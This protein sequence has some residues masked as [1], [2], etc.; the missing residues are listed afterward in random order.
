MAAAAL[1]L[2]HVAVTM[3][4]IFGSLGAGL[5]ALSLGL[6]PA[7]PPRGRARGPCW[8]SSSPGKRSGEVLALALSPLWI[9]SVGALR[10]CGAHVAAPRR[11]KALRAPGAAASGARCA[12]PCIRA[13]LTPPPPRAGVVVA[14]G[15]YKRW[16]KWGYMNYCVACAAPY[17]LWPLLF[18]AAADKVR[19]GR[20]EGARRDSAATTGAACWPHAHAQP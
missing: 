11:A 12:P 13:R 10:V 7:P 5:L 16:G 3:A 17:V 8:L 18:P 4:K 15:F 6:Q 14:G 2:P 19:A 1:A 20:E 9:A